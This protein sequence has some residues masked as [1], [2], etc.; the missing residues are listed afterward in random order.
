MPTIKTGK[1]GSDILIVPDPHSTPEHD[2]DRAHLLSKLIDDLRPPTIVRMGDL[3]SMDSL[4]SFD[5]GRW[6]SVGRTYK[7]DLAAGHDFHEKMWASWTRTKNRY[8]PRR[9]CLEGNHEQRAKRAVEVDHTLVGL[10]SFSD[11]GFDKWY[12]DVV[13]YVGSTPGT[14]EIGGVVFAHY[15][16][17]MMCKALGGVHH[18]HQKSPLHGQRGAGDGSARFR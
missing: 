14:I 2:N 15:I 16:A 5:K 6:G 17:G 3:F 7:N 12:T 8:R 18:S 13:E 1:T 10:M 9:V 11:F 4:S